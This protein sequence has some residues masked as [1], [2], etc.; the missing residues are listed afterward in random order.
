MICNNPT[1]PP[2]VRR[3]ALLLLTAMIALAWGCSTVGS[4]EPGLPPGVNFAGIWRLNAAQS[5]DPRKV[6]EKLRPKRPS[7]A[8]PGVQSGGRR[9]RGGQG[10]GQGSTQEADLPEDPAD[11]P[12]PRN[13]FSLVPNSD[14]LRNE[15]LGIKQLPESFVL[16]YGTSVRRLTPGLR[17]VVS[18][19]GGVGDQSTGWKGKNYVVEVR[20]QL[21]V[22]VQETY[23]VS[24]K[25]G[26][27][28]IVRIH[29]TGSGLPTLN[30]TRVYDPTG[31]ETPRSLPSID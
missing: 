10:P 23:S 1:G 11:A 28:L 19:P 7:S 31:S 2:A 25:N 12:L 5:D 3:A 18:V 21:G 30:L 16:D 24:N 15:V 8:A 4:Y 26:R 13:A 22:A 9:R 20:S 29:I 6:L 14:L 17:S 27:Q